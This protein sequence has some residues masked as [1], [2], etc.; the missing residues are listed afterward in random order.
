MSRRG[1]RIAVVLEGTAGELDRKVL[2]SRTSADADK[3]SVEIQDAI[4]FWILSPGD[5]IRIIEVAS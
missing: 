3:I 4:E 1:S 5:T 2:R